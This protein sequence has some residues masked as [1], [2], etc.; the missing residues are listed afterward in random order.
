MSLIIY[1]PK[2]RMFASSSLL[3][4]DV[5]IW[6][7]NSLVQK[8][9]FLVE[10]LNQIKLN[11]FIPHFVIIFPMKMKIFNSKTGYFNKTFEGRHTKTII[12]S[13]FHDEILY[14]YDLN[15]IVAQSALDYS[16]IRNFDILQA[17]IS[18]IYFQD[19]YLIV[20]CQDRKDMFVFHT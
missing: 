19:I 20:L 6:D 3:N 8:S 10:G 5:V 18:T 9:Y 2:E 11:P 4:G 15:R 7:I 14:T 13:Y 12:G 17:D 1:D 16:L